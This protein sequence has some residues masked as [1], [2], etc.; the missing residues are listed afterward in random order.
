MKL[1]PED[2]KNKEVIEWQG[3]HL[4]HYSMS[5]CSQKVRILM[6]ELAIDYTSHHVNLMRDEQ[7]SDFYLGINPKGLVPVLVHDGQVHIE[8]NDIIEYLDRQFSTANTSFLPTS[9]TE[10]TQMHELMDLED[11]LHADLRRVTFTYLAPDPSD[12][13]PQA[14]KEEELEFIGRFHEAFRLLDEKLKQHAYLLGERITLADISW[15][16]TLHRLASAGYPLEEHPH[17]QRYYQRIARRPAF[18]KQLVA[19][20]LPLRAAGAV[21]RRLIRIFK[22]SLAKDYERWRNP[23]NGPEGSPT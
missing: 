7:R 11:E 5:S 19:G 17:L 16:I 8:S 9:E 13:A 6:G 1:S 15:F 22:H 20:P 2:V 18:R 23:L 12:H 10:Q 3:L 14:E 21:Y 4:L